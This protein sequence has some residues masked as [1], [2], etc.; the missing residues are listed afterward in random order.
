MVH[1][2]PFSLLSFGCTDFHY[3]S[4]YVYTRLNKPHLYQTHLQHVHFQIS[5]SSIF[6]TS[7]SFTKSVLGHENNIS[8][9]AL[10]VLAI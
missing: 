7:Y 1:C 3:I 2:L 8:A 6:S 10:P 5:Y 9:E 4:V